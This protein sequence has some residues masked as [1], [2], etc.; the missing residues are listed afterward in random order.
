MWAS[1]VRDRH[2]TQ[3]R[4]VLSAMVDQEAFKNHVKCMFVDQKSKVMTGSRGPE[5]T[6]SLSGSKRQMAHTSSTGNRGQAYSEDG[7]CTDRVRNK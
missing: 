1:E 5:I 6:P 4:R 7:G 3:A 2:D